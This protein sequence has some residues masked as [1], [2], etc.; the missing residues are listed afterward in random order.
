MRGQKE[1]RAFDSVARTC[2]PGLEVVGDGGA[3]VLLDA[4][5]KEVRRA[6]VGG[7]WGEVDGGRD[8]GGGGGRMGRVL[9]VRFGSVFSASRHAWCG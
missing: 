6:K 3:A 1:T 4:A 7:R 5:G 8:A 2:A 9:H